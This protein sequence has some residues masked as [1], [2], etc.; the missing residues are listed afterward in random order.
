[1]RGPNY[2]CCIT[3][4]VGETSG[5]SGVESGAC[6]CAPNGT[7]ETSRGFRRHFDCLTNYVLPLWRDASVRLRVSA[8]GRA[9]VDEEEVLCTFTDAGT[10]PAR[11]R[12]SANVVSMRKAAR[13][14][15]TPR[16]PDSGTQRS[17]PVVD[18]L[19]SQASGPR[20]SPASTSTTGH[21]QSGSSFVSDIV[22]GRPTTTRRWPSASHQTTLTVPHSG[23]I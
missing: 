9:M 2:S 11:H 7:G 22:V 8:P 19:G 23:E 3:T 4:I 14:R 13:G 16:L 5:A 20:G 6:W 18:S 21:M 10:T 17:W 1:M 15:T 12:P